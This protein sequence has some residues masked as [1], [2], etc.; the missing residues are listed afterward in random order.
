MI[1]VTDRIHLDDD[2]IRWRFIR[3]PGPGGQHVNT[4][5][6]GVQLVFDLDNSP[7][8]PRHVRARMHRL[9]PGSISSSGELRIDSH[10]HRSQLKNRKAALDRLIACIRRA[11]APVKPR[12]KTSPPEAAKEK[13]LRQKKQHAEKKRLRQK[14]D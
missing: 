8:L 10:E 5:S 9:F 4:S 13:R 6:T 7:S 14:I 2:E 3:S 1:K 12:K 11:S